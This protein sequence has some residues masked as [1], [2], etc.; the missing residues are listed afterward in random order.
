MPP[1]AIVMI[2][3]DPILRS[4]YSTVLKSKGFNVVVARDG[5]EGLK[6]ARDAQPNLILLDM[7][8]PNL[9]GLEFLQQYEAKSHP[10]TKIIVFSN[11]ANPEEM[12]QALALGAAKYLIKADYSARELVDVI[13]ELLDSGASPNG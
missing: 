7:L 4:A 12:Q 9:T 6:L 8:M 5:Q 10:D 11:I 2:E 3:D 13:I 1:K